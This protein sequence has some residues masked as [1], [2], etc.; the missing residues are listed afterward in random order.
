[1]LLKK[2]MKVSYGMYIA[3]SIPSTYGSRYQYFPPILEK[4]NLIT[5]ICACY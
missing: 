4:I 3:S 2:H 1:M 5:K